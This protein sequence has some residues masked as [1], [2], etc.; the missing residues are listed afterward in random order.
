MTSTHIM[1]AVAA[2]T[3]ILASHAGAQDYSPANDFYDL[4][5]MPETGMYPQGGSK[6]GQGAKPAPPPAA[7]AVVPQEVVGGPAIFS[8]TYPIFD[9]FA[10]LPDDVVYTRA[11]IQSF[12]RPEGGTHYYEVVLVESMN[13][14]WV[15]AA[16]LA[17]SE[18]GY[19]ATL[20][21]PEENAF[22]F[23]LINDDKYFWQFP[24]DYT[25]DSHYRIKIGPFLG[26]VR[27]SDTEASLD[28][29]QW[30]SGEAWEFSNWAQNLDD[31]V[32]D[33][34]PRDNTQPNGAG[35]QNIMG[36]G[37]LNVPVPTWGDYWETVAQYGDR[38]MP[39]GYNRGFIIEYDDLPN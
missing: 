23:N 31:G 36:F 21:S 13:I 32:T 7:T 33:R 10:A 24:D 38:G 35:H 3:A 14:S 37:E 4:S 18:G 28:G 26:G 12:D 16:I 22:V 25:S 30:I 6:P 11:P 9:T 20:T 15:Q 34:D 27:V 19:L 29:W 2:S 1:S 5:A 17:Q 39:T 8:V